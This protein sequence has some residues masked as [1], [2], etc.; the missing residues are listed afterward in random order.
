MDKNAEQLN[1]TGCVILHGDV[2]VIVVEGGP[3][4]LKK[5]KHLLL[6]RIDWEV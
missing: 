2:N 3:K 1:L 4:Q 5:Y 6:T